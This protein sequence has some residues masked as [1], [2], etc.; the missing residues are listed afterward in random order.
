MAGEDDGIKST[1]FKGDTDIE[2]DALIQVYKW[3]AGTADAVSTRRLTANAFYL[4]LNMTLLTLIGYSLR[5]GINATE[6]KCFFWVL[7]V[8][9]VGVGGFLSYLWYRT[10]KS[11][12]QLNAG[13]FEVIALMEEKLPVAPYAAEW[14]ALGEGNNSTKYA[15]ITHLEMMLPKIFGGLYTLFG[16]LYVIQ[17][18]CVICKP[19]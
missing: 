1:L 6:V 8:C 7:V 17:L 13:K 5:H 16:I 9:A 10:V 11:Y 2:P 3:F 15:P 19:G 14:K 4:T 12:K 18:N